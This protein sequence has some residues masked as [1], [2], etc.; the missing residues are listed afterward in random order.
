VVLIIDV[1]VLGWMDTPTQG[2]CEWSL[3]RSTTASGEGRQ[4]RDAV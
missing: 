3:R 2:L 4:Y 1:H